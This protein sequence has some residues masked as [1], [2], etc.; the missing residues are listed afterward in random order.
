M[1]CLDGS[2]QIFDIRDQ[3]NKPSIINWNAHESKTY[4]SS[5]GILHSQ[6]FK[7][8]LINFKLTDKCCFFILSI[9]IEKQNK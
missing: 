5:C 6:N 7:R 9:M 8:N 1:A 3:L 4:T 2:L